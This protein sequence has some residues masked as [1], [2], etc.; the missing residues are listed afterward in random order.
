MRR[1][2]E[3]WPL[4]PSSTGAAPAAASLVLSDI[5]WGLSAKLTLILWRPPDD[6]RTAR[7]ECAANRTGCDRM[8]PASDPVVY[9][10]SCERKRSDPTGVMRPEPLL[11]LLPRLC[12]ARTSLALPR[13]GRTSQL[14]TSGPSAFAGFGFF[15]PVVR[16]LPLRFWFHW[17]P[18]LSEAGLR[19]SFAEKSLPVECVCERRSPFRTGC[20][21]RPSSGTQI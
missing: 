9:L 12:P 13:T 11:P 1:P 10:S 5:R 21:G 17:K 20:A 8:A 7:A 4:G 14:A 18:D 2:S 3:P 19:G 6:R 16:R 15:E